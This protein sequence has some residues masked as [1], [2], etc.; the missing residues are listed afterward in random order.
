VGRLY[1]SHPPNRPRG[2]KLVLDCAQA[3]LTKGVE[4]NEISV[5]LLAAPG[6]AAALMRRHTDSPQG[7][8]AG[9]RFSAVEEGTAYDWVVVINKAL[10][11]PTAVQTDPRHIVY[12]SMEPREPRSAGPGYHAQFATVIAADPWIRHPGLIRR[13]CPT[14][15]FGQGDPLGG[16]SGATLSFRQ[17]RDWKPPVKRARRISIVTSTQNWMPGHVARN[18]L[19]E[20]IS[21]HPVGRFVDVYGRGRIPISDKMEAIAPN[22]YHLVLENS[23]IPDY[24]SEKIS[25]AFLGYALPVYAGCT[26][27]NEYFDTNSFVRADAR[28]TSRAIETIARVL[29]EDPFDT[30]MEAVE[31]SREKVLLDYNLLSV[32]A[33]ICKGKRQSRA[34][35][36]LKPPSAFPQSTRQKIHLRLWAGFSSS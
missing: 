4:T 21:S 12:A 29:D 6:E 9:C 1:A 19:I 36:W 22:R 30:A 32:L 15:W 34:T 31:K 10:T 27:L 23:F 28:R 2:R 35:I 17:V 24:W 20:A 26:N 13:N 11:V 18:R 14:W 5:G 3:D 25:D 8:V 16:A 7:I 33:A